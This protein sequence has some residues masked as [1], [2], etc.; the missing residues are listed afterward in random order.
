MIAGFVAYA[1]GI[2]AMN[3]L[4]SNHSPYNYLLLLLP[5]VPMIYLAATI[6]REVS[7]LDEMQRKIAVEAMAFSGLATGFTCFSYLFI[8]DLGAPEFRGEWAFYVMWLYFGIGRFLSS[9]RY[10]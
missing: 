1:A 2:A 5:I 7:E 6:I 8:R 4:F 10:S 3:A 9:R